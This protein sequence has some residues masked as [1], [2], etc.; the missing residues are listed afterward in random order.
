MKRTLDIMRMLFISPEFLVILII[1]SMNLYTKDFLTL[2]GSQFKTNDEIWKFLPTL[3]LL[4]SGL[5]FTISN[6]VRAPF[7]GKNNKSLY[8]WPGY[9]GITDRVTLSKIYCLFCGA[10]AISIWIF[11]KQLPA[12]FISSIFL[13]ST[14]VS[15]TVAFFMFESSQKLREILELYSE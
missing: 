9:Q 7:E 3:P 12:Q 2:L 15:G 4:F 10:G 6:K 13:I 14:V 1:C 8:E 5:A 11:S